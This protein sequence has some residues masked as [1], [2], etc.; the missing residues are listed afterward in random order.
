MWFAAQRQPD[1]RSSIGLASNK[2]G[3][4]ANPA[5]WTRHGQILDCGFAG[6]AITIDP[7]VYYAPGGYDPG[8]GDGRHPIWMLY[9]SGVGNSDIFDLY[10]AH[11]DDYAGP[12]Q[13][14]NGGKPVS[15]VDGKGYPY[16]WPGDLWRD[17]QTGT[18]WKLQSYGVTVRAGYANGHGRSGWTYA[19][20]LAGPWYWVPRHMAYLAP[21]R[22]GDKRAIEVSFFSEGDDLDM[23]SA[24][25]SD[26]VGYRDSVQ[27]WRSTV[28]ADTRPTK[29]ET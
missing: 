1:G 12:Y 22:T 4:L 16:L 20:S 8:N 5:D 6:R 23:F 3:D 9:G 11:A 14:A 21:E 25:D 2:G 10:L 29:Q 7:V 26:D 18:F 19:D 15:S 28:S 13:A 24:N 17:P 27:H